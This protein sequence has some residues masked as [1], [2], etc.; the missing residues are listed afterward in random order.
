[1]GR[2]YTRFEPRVIFV[3]IEQPLI[4]F[5]FAA[6]EDALLDAARKTSKL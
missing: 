5:T 4:N 2:C 1:M 6:R 3:R